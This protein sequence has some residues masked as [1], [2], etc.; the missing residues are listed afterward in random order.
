M[1][2][3]T[4]AA[5]DFVRQWDDVREDALAAV[6]RV[7]GSGWLVLGDEV[8]GLETELANWWGVPHAVGVASGLDAITIGL[9]C[10][11]IGPGDRVLTTPLTAFATTLAIVQVGAEPVWSDIDETGGLDL[12]RAAEVLGDDPSIR[13]VVPVHLYGHPL[14]PELLSGLV[15]EFDVALVEDCAQSAG[16]EREGMPTG[17]VGTVA[18]TSLYPTK[19]LGAMGDG[20]VVLTADEE[21]AARARSLRDYGQ[22]GRYEHVELGLN[23]RLDELQ[24]AILRSAQLP[25]LERHLARRREVAARY[26][27]ALRGTSLR[28]IETAGG[29]SA[30][31]L[32]PVEVEDDPVGAFQRLRDAGIGVGRHYPFVCSDQPAAGGIGVAVGDLAV[33]RRLAARELSLPIHPYLT[34]DEVEAVITACRDIQR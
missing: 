19:N 31:H 30:R 1:G 12:E 20:G 13:A 10:V 6:D 25:R 26:D 32:Y 16:A 24:A 34:D 4:V 17:A 18:A 28:P 11:G 22:Q 3:T 21:V 14:D 5:N 29:R 33:A 8:A 23:S 7:G 9:R 15:A 27:E 2:I